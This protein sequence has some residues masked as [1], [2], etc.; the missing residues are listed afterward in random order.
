MGESYEAQQSFGYGGYKKTTEYTNELLVKILEELRDI[1]K[2][3]AS[4]NSLQRPSNY[5][6][7]RYWE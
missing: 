6:D 3:L 1:K 4:S 2:S 7:N 5:N